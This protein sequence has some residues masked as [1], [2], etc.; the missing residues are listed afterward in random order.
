MRT[1][2][3]PRVCKKRKACLRATMTR[4]CGLVC[5]LIKRG[6]RQ[7]GGG[8]RCG[9]AVR[10]HALVCRAA[11]GR[12]NGVRTM[13]SSSSVLISICGST[14]MWGRTSRGQSASAI[15]ASVCGAED[16]DLCTKSH[17]FGERSDTTKRY[18]GALCFDAR[19]MRSCA[20]SHTNSPT[21]RRVAKASSARDGRMPETAAT[22]V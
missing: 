20:C 14:T 18:R 16:T 22:C 5:L 9:W 15:R 10:D 12:Q 3:L 2:G 7:V 19:A 8:Q 4:I 6:R 1:H 11:A 21:Q 17:R 13:T